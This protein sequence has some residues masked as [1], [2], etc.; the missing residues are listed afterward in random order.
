MIG[1]IAVIGGVVRAARCPVFNR[2]VRYFDS[3][4]GIKMIV[5]PDNDFENSSIFCATYAGTVSFRYFGESPLE[6]LGV[7]YLILTAACMTSLSIGQY[8]RT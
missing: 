7:V 3:L 2:T 4:S 6:N 8:L 1:P 5:I